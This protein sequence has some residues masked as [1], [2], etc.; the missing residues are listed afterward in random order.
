MYCLELMLPNESFSEMVRAGR[1]TDGLEEDDLCV[2]AS[3]GCPT[4]G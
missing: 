1:Q 2:V 4:I 3:I